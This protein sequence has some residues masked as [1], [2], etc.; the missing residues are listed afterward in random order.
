M[1]KLTLKLG[2]AAVAFMPAVALAADPKF[3]NP[4]STIVTSKGDLLGLLGTVR[5][6]FYTIFLVVAVI[7]LIMAAFQYLTA[8]GDPERIK[9]AKTA[10]IYSIVAIA[11][12]LLAGGITAV[13]KDMLSGTT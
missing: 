2:A 11:I 10:L 9:K 7:F 6:W 5:D 4:P 1:N 12:A 13:V 3:K 8:A